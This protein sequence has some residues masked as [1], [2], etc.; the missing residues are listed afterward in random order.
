MRSG[1]WPLEAGVWTLGRPAFWEPLRRAGVPE[2]VIDIFRGADELDALEK[3]SGRAAA[4]KV[5]DRMLGIIRS[6]LEVLP[7]KSWRA[8]F[9]GRDVA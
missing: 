6:R 2:E 3:L 7:D 5:L 9:S 4:E 1:V 8:A